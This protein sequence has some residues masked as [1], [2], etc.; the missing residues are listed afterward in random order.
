M[1]TIMA[2]PSMTDRLARGVAGADIENP[3]GAVTKDPAEN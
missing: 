2:T 3:Q 1:P